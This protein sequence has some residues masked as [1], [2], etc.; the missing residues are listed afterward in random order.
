MYIDEF[1]YLKKA[2]YDPKSQDNPD[3]YDLR[4]VDYQM[5]KAEEE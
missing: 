2:E 3:P 1:L 5:I 4:V